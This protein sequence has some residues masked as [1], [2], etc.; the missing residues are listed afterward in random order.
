MLLLM[1]SDRV[2]PWLANAL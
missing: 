2:L 1:L